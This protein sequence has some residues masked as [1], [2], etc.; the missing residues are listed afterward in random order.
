MTIAQRIARP[1]VGALVIAHAW[2]HTVLP[3]RGLIVPETLSENFM[4]LICYGTALLGFSAAG[5]GILG[6]WPFTL[7]TRQLLVVA[8][9]Y[10]LVSLEILGHSD[11]WWGAAIDVVLLLVG[12]TGLIDRLPVPAQTTR[13][14][15]R[16]LATATAVV[17]LAY[18]ASAVM[19]PMYR[20]WG[21]MPAEHGLVLPGDETGRDSALEIQR[22]VTVRAPAAA[23][24]PWLIQ[25][26]QDRAGF[27]SYD[28]LER[29][30]GVDVHNV[31]EIRPEWQE[32]RVG[33]LVRATQPGYLGGLFGPQL[34]WTVERVEPEHALVLRHWG[35]FALVAED[36]TTTRFIIRTPIGNERTP[37]WAAAI[38]MMAFQ[39]PHFIMERRM[40]LHIKALAESSVRAS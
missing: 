25:L 34:G 18:T 21:T 10:S 39:L 20:A 28:W 40:M 32:R 8:S 11:L 17:F 29:A 4:P 24:W 23:V 37:V 26:G 9:A 19:W 7:A 16:G 13:P 33:E 3:L 5:V 14:V 35:A 31:T 22:A 6:V 12:V 2:A 30:F 27:Y 38:N 1:A 36:A 15:Q